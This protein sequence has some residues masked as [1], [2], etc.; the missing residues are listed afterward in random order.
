VSAENRLTAEQLAAL[1]TGDTVTLESGAEFSRR[2]YRTGRVVRIDP[3][4]IVINTKGPRGGSFIECYG[5]R[6]GIRVGGLGRAEL[7][8]VKILSRC[9]RKP[10][11]VPGRST[12]STGSGHG[13]GPTPRG[14][15]GCTPPSASA[16]RETRE[17]RKADPGSEARQHG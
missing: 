13:T 5:R 17:V 11:V 10:G 12:P 4:H 3:S 14:F 16:S 9:S 2:H 7:S 8:T 15:A 1:T 6:D